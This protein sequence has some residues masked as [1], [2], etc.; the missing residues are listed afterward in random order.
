M[1]TKTS[2]FM[3]VM[4]IAVK[5]FFNKQLNWSYI[6]FGALIL[7]LL[8][9]STNSSAF[10]RRQHKLFFHLNTLGL[11]GTSFSPVDAKD[12]EQAG[13][14]ISYDYVGKRGH[15]L[16]IEAHSLPSVVDE[17][18]F[19]G[20]L[21]YIG[22]RYHTNGGLYFGLGYTQVSKEVVIRTCED[23]LG[24]IVDCSTSY[25]SS[26]LGASL[27]YTYV[28]DSGFTF[29]V[30]GLYIPESPVTAVFETDTTSEEIEPIDEDSMIGAQNV[31]LVIGYTWR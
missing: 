16:A 14:G 20:S 13:S 24:F 30:S 31:G 15:S 2:Y 3:G 28:F 22:Y 7:S 4:L 1:I 9:L 23:S 26:G 11:S 5:L 19:A 8:L 18:T 10:E 6:R 12:E 29:G 25:R 27:G 21:S 17:T